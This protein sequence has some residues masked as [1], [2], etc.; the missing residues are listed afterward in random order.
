MEKGTGQGFPI[1]QLASMENIQLVHDA[2]ARGIPLHKLE[3]CLDRDENIRA[4]QS[5]CQ[6]KSA[7]TRRVA[8]SDFG[9]SQGPLIRAALMVERNRVR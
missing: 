1:R 8:R 6:T 3:A 9:E 4:L 5:C 2:L 7:I